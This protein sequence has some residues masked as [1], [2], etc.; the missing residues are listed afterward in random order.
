MVQA[1]D[2][3]NSSKEMEDAEPSKKA[4]EELFRI[5]IQVKQ[6]VVDCIFDPGCEKNLIS[7]ALVTQLGLETVPHE[8]PYV[9]EWCNSKA[10]MEVSKRC[11]LK[12]AVTGRFIDEVEC[13]V[14]PLD[15]CHVVLG[16]PYLWDRD[17]VYYRRAQEYLLVKDGLKYSMARN[18]IIERVHGQQ[19]AECKTSKQR[20]RGK[21][22]KRG[23]KL[24]VESSTNMRMGREAPSQPKH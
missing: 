9:L 4:R 15:V 11:K 7:E 2:C 18:R 24:G 21:R 3:G 16:S 6:S 13:E 22:G 12:F 10:R 5:S 23:A 17:A 1:K 20:K 8:K 19:K 14:V